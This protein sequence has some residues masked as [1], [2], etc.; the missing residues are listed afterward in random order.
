M[1]VKVALSSECCMQASR[2]RGAYSEQGSSTSLRPSRSRHY[3]ESIPKSV[4]RKHTY[5]A[6]GLPT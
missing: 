4:M 6:V 3:D 2:G 1:A 5:W